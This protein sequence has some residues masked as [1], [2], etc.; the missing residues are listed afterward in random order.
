MTEIYYRIVDRTENGKH[1][2]ALE[3]WP[4]VSRALK[5]AW[6]RHFYDHEGY[7]KKFC[8]D[9]E[10]KRWAYPTIEA[11]RESFIIRKKRQIKH[12]QNSIDRAQDT[13]AL[14]CNCAEFGSVNGMISLNILEIEPWV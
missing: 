12:C 11:A 2:M 5:G 3:E 13:L 4:V 8:L 6:V 7:R 14:A 9:G 10:G 1:F